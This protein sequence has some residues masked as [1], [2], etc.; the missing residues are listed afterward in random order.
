MASSTQNSIKTALLKSLLDKDKL[1]GNNFNEWYRN[2]RIVL[3]HEKKLHVLDEPLPQAPS[4]DST[5]EYRAAYEKKY[6]EQSE[7]ACLMLSSM[8][9]Q[10][11][12]DMEN[13][14]AHSIIKELKSMF[15]KQAQQELFQTVHAL[16]ACK[17]EVGQPV[18]NYVLKM[19]SYIDNLQRLD[20]P[21]RQDLAVNLILNSL[22]KDFDQFVM[23]YNMQGWKKSI[24]ELHQMLKTAEGA[25]VKAP[26]VLYVAEGGVKKKKWRGGKKGKSAAPK[27]PLPQKK[28]KES[29]A[30]DATCFHCEKIGHRKRNCPDYLA[31][32]KK[33]KAAGNPKQGI[34]I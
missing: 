9:P 12:R 27:N 31:E 18:S 5:A 13:L 23:N 26:A 22:T 14:D 20:S 30:K 7:I 8:N 17:M 29:P 15:E 25:M 32:V 28:K 6:D 4:D 10:L 2:M 34:S 19:K 21:I 3:K 33:I 16:H 24:S 11:Q 1:D